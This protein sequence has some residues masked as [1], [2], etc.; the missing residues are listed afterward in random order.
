VTTTPKQIEAE[1]E[2]IAWFRRS[3]GHC[4]G[5]GQPGDWCQCTP[6]NACGCRSLHVMG[7]GIGRDP[8]D[9]FAESSPVEV[10]QEGM[11]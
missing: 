5:C 2:A 4:H 3:G 6:R 1:R 9:V 7:S 10:E 8:A 11:F